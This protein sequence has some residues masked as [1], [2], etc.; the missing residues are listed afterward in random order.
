M[1]YC[2]S[3]G[4]ELIKNA[5][6]CTKCGT[7]VEEKVVES[8]TEESV[9]VETETTKSENKQANND[10]IKE[11]F[12]D[13]VS[14]AKI[15]V[16]TNGYFNYFKGTTKLP[17]AAIGY[18]ETNNGWI[19]MAVFAIVSTFG[20]YSVLRGALVSTMRTFGGGVES[21]FGIDNFAIGMLNDLIPN[22]FIVS[23]LLYLIFIGSAFITL[24][25][26]A[27]SKQTFTK[28]LT[29]LGGL[30]TPNILILGIAGVISLLLSSG[31]TSA[32]GLLLISF[33]FLLCFAAYN[34]YLYSRVSLERLDKMYVLLISNLLVLI[35]LAILT[36]MLLEPFIVIMNQL[37]SMF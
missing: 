6:F 29:E 1:D 5:A 35:L 30:F 14:S 4:N 25:V 7:R 20:V 9:K 22:L 12:S 2:K 37:D 13:T 24:K 8:T 23:I 28:L 21:I 17:T 31:I 27:N 32:I 11:R 33:S 18:Q 26:T 19:Q 3:C 36:A 10:E 34:F 16:E 15:A